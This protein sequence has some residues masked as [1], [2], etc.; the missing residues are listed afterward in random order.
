MKNLTTDLK[1]FQFDDG[2]QHWI[3]G[4]NKKDA[5]SWYENNWANENVLNY[6]Y[7][8][9]E[10]SEDNDVQINISEDTNLMNIINK[11]KNQ[12]EKL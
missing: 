10:L 9:K 6:G 7:K 3:V 4:K 1:I 11:Y 8:V 12:K 5:M 2:K